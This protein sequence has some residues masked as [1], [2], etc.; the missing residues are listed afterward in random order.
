MAS[1]GREAD[2]PM[3]QLWKIIMVGKIREIIEAKPGEQGQSSEQVDLPEVPTEKE[4]IDAFKTFFNSFFEINDNTIAEIASIMFK[5]DITIEDLQK[6]L[7]LEG[8]E[9]D[10]LMNSLYSLKRLQDKLESLKSPA[11]V[12][13][14]AGG[15]WGKRPKKA[16]RRR[17]Q[18]GGAD[19]NVT[20]NVADS[21]DRD[22]VYNVSGLITSSRDVLGTALDGVSELSRQ[23]PP[24]GASAITG[25]VSSNF[26]TTVAPEIGQKYDGGGRSKKRHPKKT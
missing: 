15:S 23:S 20:Y 18:K 9:S 7:K 25:S 5:Y 10:E 19:D 16:A 14:T 17:T 26:L 13:G 21:Y 11:P 12:T 3:S 22:A 24:F 4:M 6:K 1:E 8:Q 2:N